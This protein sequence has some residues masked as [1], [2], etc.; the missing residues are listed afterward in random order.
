MDVVSK[1]K[2]LA[3]RLEQK[4]AFF[5][6][7]TIAYWGYPAET[8]S[9][10][11]EDGYILGIHRI[12]FGKDGPGENPRPPVLLNHGMTS[13]SA[14]W[15][16]GPPDKSLAYILADAG[17]QAVSRVFLN[18]FIVTYLHLQDMM[19]GWEILGATPIPE[20]I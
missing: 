12:P 17:T 5:Q 7:Q 14:Q 20:T 9:V 8:H 11:T 10:V 13:C 6:P 19:F 15:A 3:E 4:S 16:F 1:V 18:I 2:L